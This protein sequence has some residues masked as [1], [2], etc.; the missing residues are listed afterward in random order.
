MATSEGTRIYDVVTRHEVAHFTSHKGLVNTVAF[1]LNGTYLASGGAD[2]MIH[3]WNV[4]TRKRAQSLERRTDRV[5]ALAF[6]S[7]NKLVSGANRNFILWDIVSGQPYNKH[8]GNRV[9]EDRSLKIDTSGISKSIILETPETVFT[10]SGLSQNGEF[11]AR[12]RA[13]AV[14]KP[15]RNH[16]KIEIFLSTP[17]TELN[18]RS[19]P[20][21]HTSLIKALAFSPDGKHLASG[22]AY[23]TICLYDTNTGELL[24]CFEGHE[25]SITALTYH[26]GGIVLACGSTDGTTRTWDML[27]KKPLLTYEGHTDEVTALAFSWNF[28]LASRSK[29][30]TVL[31]WENPASKQVYVL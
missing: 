16:E 17:N 18:Q 8:I 4:K 22:S 11:V 24:L 14:P 13:L 21:K 15:L 2:K 30:G 5:L 10:A 23:K 6:I 3:I 19:I 9:R 26:P 12:A 7:E 29:D 31:I 1:S 27:N 25:D 28:K 20:T